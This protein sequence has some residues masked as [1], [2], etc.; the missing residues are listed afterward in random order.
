MALSIRCDWSHKGAP[1]IEERIKQAAAVFLSPDIQRLVGSRWFRTGKS[2]REALSNPIP[3]ETV[4]TSAAWKLVPLVLDEEK[5][6]LNLWSGPHGLTS[7]AVSINLQ[8][9]AEQ[10]SVHFP[11]NSFLIAG[12]E[13]SSLRSRD[14]EWETI[15]SCARM[16]ANAFQGRCVI[17]TDEL[18][19]VSLQ[20]CGIAEQ[21]RANVA[22]AAVLAEQ[23]RGTHPTEMIVSNPLEDIATPDCERLREIVRLLA[24][25]LPTAVM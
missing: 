22:H 19:D 18:A 17:R 6:V 1:P 21:S 7:C 9:P 2:K 25:P 10:T 20:L 13:P 23:F 3:I 16:L 15:L 8:V 4:A 24:A 11:P 12:V 14:V 5:Y